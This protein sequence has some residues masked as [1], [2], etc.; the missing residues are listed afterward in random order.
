M[1]RAQ[2]IGHELTVVDKVLYFRPRQIATQPVLSLSMNDDLLSFS[3]RLTSLGQPPDIM[4]RGWDPKQKQVI[5]GKSGTQNGMMGGTQG[6]PAAVKKAFGAAVSTV[7]QDPVFSKAEADSIAMGQFNESALDYISGEGTCEG[8]PKLRSG[9]VIK[10]SD[11]GTR[12]S[13][14]YYVT[15]VRHTLDGTSGYASTFSVRRNAA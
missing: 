2:R 15:A 9:T 13:G 6:G 11:V 5:V 3:A 12:F 1:G 8:N 4:V 10:I 14:D 7:V